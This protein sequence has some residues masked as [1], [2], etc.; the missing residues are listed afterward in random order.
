VTRRGTMVAKMAARRGGANRSIKARIQILFAQR[1]SREA[2]DGAPD[3]PLP[4][5]EW[6]RCA[7]ETTERDYRIG[8]AL[9]S[10][11]LE[12]AV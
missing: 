12:G 4:P 11:I 6:K 9:S 1:A 3:V 10:A 2:R 7:V 5:L 8:A